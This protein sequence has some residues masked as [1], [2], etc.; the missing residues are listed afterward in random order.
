MERL[1]RKCGLFAKPEA[2]IRNSPGSGVA[3]S[4]EMDEIV[5]LL[6]SLPIPVFGI[7]VLLALAVITE[8][9]GILAFFGL[10][11][12]ELHEREFLRH[13]RSYSRLSARRSAADNTRWKT[14]KARQLSLR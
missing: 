14:S 11:R 5:K 10:P 12:Q 9:E 13:H 3:E 1:A 2:H 8:I 7:L 6:Y 4:I